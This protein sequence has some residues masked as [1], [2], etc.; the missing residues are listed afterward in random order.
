M[1]N[2]VLR[3][4]FYFTV[5][6]LTMVSV[7]SGSTNLS[8]MFQAQPKRSTA[9]T[10]KVKSSVYTNK[11][12]GFRLTLPES[13]KGCSIVVSQWQG[14]DGRTYDRGETMP[15]PVTGPLI[16]VQ[17][18]LSTKAEPRADIEI[19][20]FTHAQWHLIEN[21][22]LIVSAAPFGPS[23]MGRNAKYVFALP[24]RFNYSLLPGWEEVSEIIQRQ[25]LQPF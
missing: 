2:I 12:Y 3:A 23:E 16:L 22:T 13:W 8:D 21:D 24:P 15:P 19:M 7:A 4:I 11:K 10:H 17:H 18:P 5:W 6:S 20:I 1:P 14:G 9:N 25:P